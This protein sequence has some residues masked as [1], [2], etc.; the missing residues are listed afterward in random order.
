[1]AVRR[2]LKIPDDVMPEAIITLGYSNDK[3]KSTRYKIE[4]ITYIEEWGKTLGEIS[5]FPLEKHKKKIKKIKKKGKSFLEKL[6]E[7]IK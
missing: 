3:P 1:L 7:K 4:K 2:I 5:L 6:K